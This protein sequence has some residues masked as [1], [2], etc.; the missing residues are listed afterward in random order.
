MRLTLLHTSPVHVATF[1]ALAAEAGIEVDHVVREDLLADARTL[2]PQS[3]ADRVAAALAGH[4]VV[5]CTCSTIGAVAEAHGALRV[6]P[7]RADDAARLRSRVVVLAAL[8]STIEPTLALLDE[9]GVTDVEAHVV[10][11]A[12]A[13]F[14]AG[15]VSG[16]L[17]L[18]GAEVA[19]H[20]GTV[21]LAQ[22]SMAPAADRESVLASPRLG[23]AAALRLLRSRAGTPAGSPGTAPPPPAG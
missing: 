13:R 19:R 9:E 5:L 17:A 15:D 11:G 4:D 1:D 12:W 10:E 23:F 16:Y 6:D 8:E 21:V 18:I 7:P 2:G 14:E 3:V 20:D 22:A